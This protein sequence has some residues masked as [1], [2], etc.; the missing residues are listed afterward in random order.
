MLEISKENRSRSERNWRGRKEIDNVG[1]GRD[2][3]LIKIV[4]GEEKLV[5]RGEEIEVVF[6]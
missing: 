3:N 4:D 2:Q 6:E 1:D 5:V